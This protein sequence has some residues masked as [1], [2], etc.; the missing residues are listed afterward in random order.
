M[1][2]QLVVRGAVFGMLTILEPGSSREEKTLCRCQCGN[3]KLIR[4]QN[5][6]NGKSRSCGCRVG[7]AARERLIVHGKH[8]TPEYSSWCSA[9][10]RCH[11][12]R[13]PRYAE[14]GGRGI[15]VCDRWRNSFQA[16]LNDMGPRPAGSSI[17]R[18][19]NSRGYE[20]GN[21]RWATAR[22]QSLNRPSWTRLLS[23]NGV[24]KSLSGWAEDLGISPASLRGRL[25][26]GWPLEMAL[27]AP[28]GARRAGLEVR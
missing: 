27:T 16:F 7:I 13:H 14:W 15:A 24:E 5:I 20:P 12:E 17:D 2:K 1:F 19:D 25:G 11:N 26:A 3:E 22:E 18:I 21:C 8:K 28:R 6:V 9:K 23:M 10:A 4:G